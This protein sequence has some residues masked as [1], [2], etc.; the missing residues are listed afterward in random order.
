MDSPA[1]KNGRAAAAAAV[2]GAAVGWCH[3]VHTRPRR[4]PRAPTGGWPRKKIRRRPLLW[5]LCGPAPTCTSGS[6]HL[7]A[8]T[9][10]HMEAR[11]AHGGGGSFVCA[12]T[13]RSPALATLGRFQRAVDHALCAPAAGGTPA[14]CW[15][16]LCGDG[17]A[18]G[19]VPAELPAR[20]RARTHWQRLASRLAWLRR[21]SWPHWALMLAIARRRPGAARDGRVSLTTP[22]VMRA[23][24]ADGRAHHAHAA[25]YA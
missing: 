9:T 4:C 5:S 24:V 12:C 11:N 18:Q 17:R 19:V 20:A 1:N 10:S 15:I 3:A 6:L 16:V 7:L 2:G 25:T 14:G 8:P 22:A 21:P 13:T 23:E